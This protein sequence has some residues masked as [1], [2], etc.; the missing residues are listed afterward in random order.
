MSGDATT[1]METPALRATKPGEP[2]KDEKKKGHADSSS[3]AAD[4][5]SKYMRRPRT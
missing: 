1:V 5:L 4:I 3:A 2:L